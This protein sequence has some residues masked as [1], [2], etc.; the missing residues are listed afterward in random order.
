MAPAGR[1]PLLERLALHRPELRAWALYD[2]ANSA[3]ITTVITAVWPIYFTEVV[4]ADLDDAAFRHSLATT[5][6]LTLVAAMA[7]ILGAVA[8]Y[9][10]V[11]KRFLGLFAGVGISATACMFL[12]ERGD[13]MLGMLL[14]I[15]ANLGAAGSFVFYDSL[16]PHVAREGEMDRVSTAGYA[17]GYM[18]GG[19]LLLLNLTWIENPEWFGMPEGTFPTRLAF[20]S[21]A[22]WWALFSIPLFLRVPEPPRTLE[23]DESVGLN[24][25]RVAVS[26]L[27]ETFRELRGYRQ[28]FLLLLAFLVYND[29]ITTIY[30]M[31]TTIGV[32]KEFRKDIM[33]GAIIAVQFV[34]IPF[35]FGFGALAG[36]FGTKRMILLGIAAYAGITILGYRMD[37]E[38]EF[39]AL[40][41]LVGMVQGGCQA[42]SRSLFASMI[43]K[44]K[45]GELFALFAVGEKFAGI[46]GPLLFAASIWVTGSTQTAILSILVFFA[47]GGFLLSRVDVQS[48]QRTAREIDERIA[49]GQST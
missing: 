45:S 44:H 22:L 39:I 49:A 41:V 28:A 23:S 12:V 29:G 48:G 4:G 34:G 43:P 9:R 5:I 20:V 27:R 40:A 8:D 7:P 17:M 37:T 36:R 18:G 31:A 38:N 21:V 24:P 19:L 11:K 10:A 1:Q 13:W 32:E 47:V 15:L 3:L 30:R 6:A 14:F 2:W 16:L 25:L 33:I 46:F 42:L 35:A 26:R